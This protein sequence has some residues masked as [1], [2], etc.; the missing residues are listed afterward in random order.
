MKGRGRDS[1][2]G[3]KRAGCPLKWEGEKCCSKNQ[4]SRKRKKTGGGKERER[5]MLE[6]K[7]LPT[8]KRSLFGPGGNLTKTA[9]K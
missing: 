6:E 4:I 7:V 2:L 9:S 1:R 3:K 5:K 8:E